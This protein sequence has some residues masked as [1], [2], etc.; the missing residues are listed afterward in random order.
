MQSFL[1]NF[2][3]MSASEQSASLMRGKITGM[4]SQAKKFPSLLLLT[5][6]TAVF[7][8]SSAGIARIPACNP[9]A[10]GGA[11]DI[12]SPDELS[13]VKVRSAEWRVSNEAFPSIW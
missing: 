8:F 9:A 13:P 12:L 10:S 6:G 5:A 2:F 11:G 7:L 4:K 3:V 1:T